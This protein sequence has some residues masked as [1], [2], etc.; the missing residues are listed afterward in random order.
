MNFEETDMFE[1]TAVLDFE[2]DIVLP[3]L[4]NCTIIQVTKESEPEK[5]L[6][7]DYNPN[8][9]TLSFK[10]GDG[11]FQGQTAFILYGKNIII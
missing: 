3:T 1:Y 7:Y 4:R 6:N 2:V 8:N 11:L 5:F 10:N 9:T